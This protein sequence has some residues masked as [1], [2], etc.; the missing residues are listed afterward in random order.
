M[1]T[2]A[3]GKL[4][5][6]AF[7]KCLVLAV[8][9]VLAPFLQPLAW[10]QEEPINILSIGEQFFLGPH[11]QYLE[12]KQGT[13]NI[14]DVVRASH[15][16]KFKKC[17]RT[18][19]GFGFT[20]SVFW[21]K[22]TLYNPGPKN[23]TR[24]LE[25]EYP[26]LDYVDLYVPL[27]GSG[28][29]IYKEGDRQSFYHRPIKYRN[30]VFIL[31]I[32]GNS[33]QDYF[34]RVKTSSS[35][36]LPARLYTPA[37][38]IDKV[39]DE[40]TALGFYFGILFAMLAYNLIL[41]F[42]IREAVY[43]YYV[44]FVIF[45]FLFQ[46]D[47]TGLAFKYFWP[48]SIYW[49]NESLPFFILVSY[50]FGTMFTRQILNSRRYAPI[51]DKILAFFMVVSL[52]CAILSLVVPYEISIKAATLITMT[53]LV[54][55]LAGFLC[56]YRGYRPARYYALAWSISMAGASIYA[57]KSFG[58]LP[59]NFVTVWGLQVGS[60]WEVILLSMALSDRLSLLQKE[61]DRIQAEYTRKLEEANLRLEEFAKTL[62]EKVRQRTLELEKSNALLMQQAEEMRLAEERA[63]R[64]SKAKSDFLANMSHEIRTPLNA[65]TGITALAL[66]MDL[67]DKLRDYLNIIKASAHSLLNLVND[68]LDLSKIEAGKME[69]EETDFQLL[70]VMENMADMFTEI[71]SEKSIE[72]I[73]DIAPD[74]P[75]PLIGDPMRLG[76]LLT[77]LVSN[78]IK[79]T[80]Q[81]QV[82]LQCI[83]R[84][85]DAE[86]SH[87]SFRVSDTG[88]GIEKDR[89]EYLF[90]MFT[91]ADSST[92]R[93]FGGTGLGLTIC[94]R[95]ASL[96]G[97]TIQVQSEI[98]KGTT[99][100]FEV[101]LKK[102]KQKDPWQKPIVEL[103]EEMPF[104]IVTPNPDIARSLENTLLRLGVPKKTIKERKYEDIG[105]YNDFNTNAVYLV[106]VNSTQMDKAIQLARSSAMNR[107]LLLVPFGFESKFKDQL[108][109]KNFA[110]ST[111]PATI[112][113]IANKLADLVLPEP[114]GDLDSQAT[115]NVRFRDLKILVVEDNEINQMVAKEILEKYGA[116]VDFASNGQEAL[117]KAHPGYDII[118][119]DIQMPEMDGYEA[120][121]HLRAR[122][123]FSS[124]PII[125]M[126][127]GVFKEDRQRCFQA[128]MND[129]VL[130]PV[131]PESVLEVLSK[132]IKPDKMFLAQ[133]EKDTASEYYPELPGINTQEAKQRF[134]SNSSLYL[135]L[136]RNFLS[137]HASIDKKV[138][139]LKEA[140]N[141]AEMKRLF[142]TLKGVSANL[143]LGE[144]QQL[145]E[146]AEHSTQD[147][148]KLKD[149]ILPEILSHISQLGQKILHDE[150]PGADSDEPEYHETGKTLN[151][152][153]LKNLI[154]HLDELLELND[155][156]CE[157]V[158]EEIRGKIHDKD[159]EPLLSQLDRHIK[160]LEY[161]SAR[162]ILAKLNSK[163]Q[164]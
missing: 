127:A 162:E 86:C 65:I 93:R 35:L 104:F 21:F 80:D 51:L 98:G 164:S 63:E 13:M 15:L 116:K 70:D 94:K 103:Q 106:D 121:K 28:Y 124:I 139:Q 11:I 122:E 50:L 12:D 10:P 147:W 102:S 26:L 77:N 23:V 142:H 34:L 64:A 54:H 156:E 3:I 4:A 108:L 154:L 2:K 16:G 24:Y 114:H 20:S 45:Y 42:T 60:A 140:G 61:K 48:N 8:C 43:L 67:P 14:M 137:E 17:K 123:E 109:R 52:I 96:M 100:T 145:F 44:L 49:A 46:L 68:I 9:L 160:D 29:R 152:L 99:F 18:S 128:G 47:L 82:L 136:L 78:A 112:K 161:E 113:R 134:G 90:D 163:I 85:E 73:I 105:D 89:L 53:V 57:M 148:E 111:K 7:G 158:W 144:L 1:K 157:E 141:M 32:P 107:L 120:T 151:N 149:E 40:E 83:Q 79:F 129:F 74:V 22:F 101:T 38:F 84:G 153:E 159:L 59:N 125:A 110:T 75:N 30:L 33:T 95:I 25:I 58:L 135:K 81:G 27:P 97:G 39:E 76:Q 118:F 6:R 143:A 117:E 41:F 36:N 138:A 19:P 146:R 72:F 62:E 37:G 31:E 132:W 130:K 133:D 131:T 56:L 119:M 150:T 155:I 126:T 88:I 66:E 87:L 71:A 91:Q 115:Q 69:L 92:T 5:S 55:I